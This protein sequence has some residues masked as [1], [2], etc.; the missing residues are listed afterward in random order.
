MPHKLLTLPLTPHPAPALPLND[1]P[2]FLPRYCEKGGWQVKSHLFASLFPQWIVWGHFHTTIWRQTLSKPYNSRNKD[3]EFWIQVLYLQ[4]FRVF[5]RF[6]LIFKN[7]KD[8]RKQTAGVLH[9]ENYKE[10]RKHSTTF[11]TEQCNTLKWRHCCFQHNLGSS[12]AVISSMI[13]QILEICHVLCSFLKYY[14]INK[15][16]MKLIPLPQLFPHPL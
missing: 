11:S 3:K 15:Y 13:L 9:M 4:E 10:D 8:S 14:F 5:G 12:W 2:S 6:S 16:F 7:D 1:Y